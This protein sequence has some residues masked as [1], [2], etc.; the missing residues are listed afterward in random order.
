MSTTNFLQIQKI[1]KLNNS[2]KSNVV[3]YKLT[4]KDKLKELGMCLIFALVLYLFY[5]SL[6]AMLLLPIFAYVYHKYYKKQLIKQA[7]EKMNGQFR[8][9]LVSLAAALR[10][11][12]SVENG[13][14]E[15][16][17][18][19]SVMYGDN[20][21]ICLELKKVINSIALGLPAEDAFYEFAERSG[22]EDIATFADVF[23]I[24]KRTGGDLV[25][26]IRKTSADISAKVDTKNEIS[27][28]VSAKKLEQNIMSL[29]PIA[30]ILYIDFT[31]DGLLD[32]LYGNPVGIAI[33]TVCL[34]LYIFAYFLGRKIIEIEV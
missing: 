3:S 14:K 7:K 5:R 12:Y 10:A 27:V 23:G 30:I 33:M 6:P 4:G 22:T 9:A 26:I 32:P 19:M 20:S 24:A 28:L 11:G 16:Y 15:S 31:S 2:P 8:D 13:L 34:G 1:Q 29:M 18:E 21:P 17:G 25:E